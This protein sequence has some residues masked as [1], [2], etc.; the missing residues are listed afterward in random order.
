[1]QEGLIQ[2]IKETVQTAEAVFQAA[3][4]VLVLEKKGIE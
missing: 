2:D 1:L 3:Q 4:D